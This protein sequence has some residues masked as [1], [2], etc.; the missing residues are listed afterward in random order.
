M[1]H[2]PYIDITSKEVKNIERNISLLDDVLARH[3]KNVLTSLEEWEDSI[4]D[5]FDDEKEYD[6]YISDVSVISNTVNGILL[7]IDKIRDQIYFLNAVIRLETKY[8]S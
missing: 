3:Y 1:K 5:Q 2:S 8:T 4:K 6:D 7:N